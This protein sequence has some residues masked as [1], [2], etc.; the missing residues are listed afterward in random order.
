MP[1]DE[2]NPH[3]NADASPTRSVHHDVL[4]INP[5]R[6]LYRFN[7]RKTD[8]ERVGEYLSVDYLG[9]GAFGHRKVMHVAR[10]GTN[11]QPRGAAF[12]TLPVKEEP[13]SSFVCCY[14]INTENLNYRNVW[15]QAEWNDAPDTGGDLA[16]PAEA[17]DRDIRVLIAEH[18]GRVLYLNIPKEMLSKAQEG[19]ALVP[20]DQA[21]GDANLQA[22]DLTKNAEVWNL[23]RNGCVAGSADYGD[24]N[25]PLINLASLVPCAEKRHKRR[26]EYGDRQITGTLDFKWQRRPDRDE[27]QYDVLVAFL[28][29]KANPYRMP[30]HALFE[31]F[32]QIAQRWQLDKLGIRVGFE[33]ALPFDAFDP[34]DYDI[35]VCLDPMGPEVV[36]EQGKMVPIPMSELG[37]YAERVDRGVATM[38]AGMPPGLKRGDGQVMEAHEYPESA[39]FQHFVVHEFG[40]AL[41]LLHLHQSPYLNQAALALLQQELGVKPG[42]DRALDAA[43]EK[44]MLDQLGIQVP[45]NYVTEAIREPWPG[46]ANYSEWPEFAEDRVAAVKAHLADSVMIGLAGH[47][48]GKMANISPAQYVTKPSQSDLDWLHALYPVRAR[49]DIAELGSSSHQVRNKPLQ[50]RVAEQ[51]PVARKP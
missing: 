42:D 14:L 8:V 26:K 34:L 9:A 40:H 2:K 37:D 18:G 23:L 31:R 46:N 28:P 50:P 44:R 5:N 7:V 17:R 22:I 45:S 13:A 4:V 48:P 33:T 43:V 12:A 25:T 47:A 51:S 11:E 39:A 24:L 27:A 21:A 1:A 41:G 20:A 16:P 6:D 3:A 49:S 29:L 19:W 30:Q 32:E 35:L 38:F 15:T 36:D 10:K